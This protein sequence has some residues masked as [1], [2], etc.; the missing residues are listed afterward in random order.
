VILMVCEAFEDILERIQFEGSE[1]S[2]CEFE[3]LSRSISSGGMWGV[4]QLPAHGL[5]ALLKNGA[6]LHR[7]GLVP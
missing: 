7:T 3:S 1:A 4:G 2:F 6:Q 5:A